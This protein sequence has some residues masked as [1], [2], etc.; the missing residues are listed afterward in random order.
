MA[1]EMRDFIG[2]WHSALTLYGI[3]AF[4]IY[5]LSCLAEWCATISLA[6]FAATLAGITFVQSPNI[7]KNSA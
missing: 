5:S 4:N 2:A 3:C 1:S 7:E 6:C